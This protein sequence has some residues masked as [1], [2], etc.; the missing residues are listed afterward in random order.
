MGTWHESH[1]RWRIHSVIWA[2]L[3]YVITG[4]LWLFLLVPGWIAWGIISIW[5][6]YP[7]VRG[8]VSM[9]RQEPVA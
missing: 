8:M 5:F 4:P 1:F 2:G 3:L 6:L 9:N 7:I